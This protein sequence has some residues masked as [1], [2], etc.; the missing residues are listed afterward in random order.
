LITIV[1]SFWTTASSTSIAFDLYHQRG[2]KKKQKQKQEG[3]KITIMCLVI[4]NKIWGKK[5]RNI[6]IIIKVNVS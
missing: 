4:A 6:N 2:K 3:G 5:H 1:S